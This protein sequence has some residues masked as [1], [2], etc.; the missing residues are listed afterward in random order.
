MVTTSRSQR[1]SVMSTFWLSCLGV[2][3]ILFTFA[4]LEFEDLHRRAERSALD[5]TTTIKMVLEKILIRADSD[6]RWIVSELTPNDML[7]NIDEHR[8]NILEGDIRL[9]QN[10][11]EEITGYRVFNAEGLLVL[12]GAIPR[13]V[14]NVSDRAWFRKLKEDNNLDAVLSD[15]IVGRSTGRAVAIYAVAIRD[16]DRNFLGEAVAA[17]DLEEFRKL[18]RGIDVGVNGAIAIRRTDE[19]GVFI[20]EP[21]IGVAGKMNRSKV[22]QEIAVGKDAGTVEFS[23]P[24]DG[25]TRIYGFSKLRDFPLLAAVGISRKHYLRPIIDQ[26]MVLLP[27]SLSIMLVLYFMLRREERL[28][29]QLAQR[30]ETFRHFF[31]KNSSVMIQV[32]PNSGRILAT[33]EAAENY[34]G[35]TKDELMG[36]NIA[37]INTLNVDEIK[38]ERIRA[39]NE[40]RSYFSFNHK[41]ASGSVRDVE[42]FSTPMDTVNGKILFSIVH[43]VT[44]R[45]NIEKQIRD[46]LQEQSAILNSDIVGFVKSKDRIIVWNNE[47]YGKMLGYS[48]DE[49]IGMPTRI[50]YSD[51]VSYK[52]FEDQAYQ[53]IYSRGVF[54]TQIQYMRKDH[55]SAWFDISGIIINPDSDETIWAFIDISDLKETEVN[56]LQ[57]RIIAENAAQSKENFL[58]MM[59]HEI[60]TPMTGIIGMAEFLSN[61]EMG[62]EQ[63][64]YINTLTSSAKSLLVILNDILDYSKI[65]VGKLDIEA[66][67]FDVIRLTLDTCQLYTARA[68]ERGNAIGIDVGDM[69]S[70]VV[71]GDPTRIRQVLGNLI[72]NAIKF[73]KHGVI[74]IRLRHTTQLEGIRLDFEI[75]DNGIGISDDDMG[76][77]FQPFSQVDA[78]TARKF[79]GTGLGLAISKR[80]VEMMGGEISATSKFGRGTIFRFSCNVAVGAPSVEILDEPIVH[81]DPMNILLAEDNPINRM[82][83]KLNLE[84]RG[85]RLTMV[86]NGLQAYE[87]A[88]CR[89]Y[90]LILM[91]MQMPIMD[92]SEATRKIRTLRAPHS[93][94]PIV[95][96]TADA[97]TDHKQHYIDAGLNEFLTKPIDWKAVDKVLAK[98]YGVIKSAPLDITKVFHSIGDHQTSGENLPIFDGRYIAAVRNSM[99]SVEFSQLVEEVVS[100]CMKDIKRLRDAAKNSDIQSCHA[101]AH[102]LKGMLGNMGA[103]RAMAY[104]GNLQR[105]DSCGEIA[106][107]IDGFETVIVE[108]L[109]ALKQ[110]WVVTQ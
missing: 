16:A 69:G 61:M 73:T 38:A 21:D 90:D 9:H 29:H 107:A 42:V 72:G 76:H 49:L 87:A 36:M 22:F 81:V 105:T 34:Y 19:A 11:F 10:R 31:E 106:A 30:E 104:A 45:K 58:A 99:G 68:S 59:S 18:I 100:L 83:I 37:K 41:L 8:R 101:I 65:Q 84:Q 64:I 98:F 28:A 92:G 110:E 102:E 46:L 12:D 62:S 67:S 20:R 23:S 32:E 97:I 95:A 44:A 53:V 15:I 43:D 57:A 71:Q 56:L 96:L 2:T 6:V 78:G 60:R 108:T 3:A 109:D 33:N 66:L 17:I 14:I 25:I 86:E 80:L 82:I 35:Y 52:I 5:F 48:S 1:T 26:A 39:L 7:A 94:V 47:A 63:K 75:E 13:V 70:L 24:A 55:S 79:G 27:I 74:S 50:F 85:H 103:M 51:D 77:L 91:D 88:A 93:D 4:W 89:A 40:E 54:R